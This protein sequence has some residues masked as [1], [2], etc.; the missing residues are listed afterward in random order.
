MLVLQLIYHQT[1]IADLVCLL[2]FDYILCGPLEV[3]SDWETLDWKQRDP[4]VP[5]EELAVLY[6]SFNDHNSCM[7]RKIVSLFTCSIRSVFS[8]A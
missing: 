1:V 7:Q 3:T 2:G 6:V 5:H 4:V 8:A